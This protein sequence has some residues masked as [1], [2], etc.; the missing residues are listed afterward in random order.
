MHQRMKKWILF[1]ILSFF[2]FS[3]SANLFAVSP[4]TVQEY[5]EQNDLQF[6][7]LFQLYLKPLDEQGLDEEEKQFL[8]L[9]VQLP[10]DSQEE[11]GKIIFK[12]KQVTAA[13][14]ERMQ[15]EINDQNKK[16]SSI[17]EKTDQ[18]IALDKWQEGLPPIDD[19]SW[20]W[21]LPDE[22]SMPIQYHGE[23]VVL[24]SCLYYGSL[25]ELAKNTLV[26]YY[27]LADQE[28]NI[29]KGF[30]PVPDFALALFPGESRKS[31]MTV[32]AYERKG[33]DFIFTE[34]W[35][36]PFKDMLLDTDLH[37]VVRHHDIAFRDI[38]EEWLWSQ[39]LPTRLVLA[40]RERTARIENLFLPILEIHKNSTTLIFMED[41]IGIW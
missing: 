5:L 39:E 10:Q 37:E 38:F 29:S 13:L 22:R 32:R 2:L 8:A 4:I 36:M 34:E 23:T 35:E 1:F 27:S 28:A 41:E 31:K 40:S 12:E 21:L 3:L 6:S 9:L 20:H 26:I 30:I 7:P 25:E 18:V 16:E 19:A 33:H 11:Y 14:L 15:Q 17:E 24:A